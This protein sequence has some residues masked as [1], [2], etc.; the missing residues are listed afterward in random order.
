MIKNIAEEKYEYVELFDKPALFTN[1]RID[2]SNVPK[3]LYCYD[4]RGSDNDP[5]KLSTVENY[6]FVNHCGTVL[7]TEPLGIPKDGYIKV[8]GKINFLGE[9]MNLK[10]FCEEHKTE[11]DLSEQEINTEN[12]PDQNTKIGGMQFE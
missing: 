6:V 2:H 3:G 9:T 5:G 7:T 10:K 1:L 12:Q 8:R 4:L 11:I